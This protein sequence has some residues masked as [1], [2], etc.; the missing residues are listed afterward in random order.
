MKPV[1]KAGSSGGGGTAC[2]GD[3]G[4]RSARRKG[5]RGLALKKT[6]TIIAYKKIHPGGTIARD[7][8]LGSWEERSPF[9]CIQYT[10]PRFLKEAALGKSLRLHN[11]RQDGKAGAAAWET[12]LR[13][14][15]GDEAKV[16]YQKKPAFCQAVS[17]KIRR[18][19]HGIQT[20]AAR[21][22]QERKMLGQ[23]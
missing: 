1:L 2:T 8:S 23:S 20:G 12:D 10:C 22:W 19:A 17:G 9:I 7:L 4:G 21:L 3:D 11:L 18:D 6:V 5:K 16:G 14:H 15:E 13:I